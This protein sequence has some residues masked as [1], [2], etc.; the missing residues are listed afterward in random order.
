MKELCVNVNIII[1][2]QSNIELMKSAKSLLVAIAMIVITST[3]H[4][5]NF[6]TSI[7]GKVT[8]NNRQPIEAVTVLI[9][10]TTNGTF[11]DAQGNYTLKTP[12]GNLT[13]IIKSMLFETKEIKVK[14]AEG[15]IQ[16]VD[17][18]LED[19]NNIL[20]EIAVVGLTP[21]QQLRETPYNVTAVEAKK[22]HNLSADLN[23]VLNRT[24]GVR[25]RESGGMGSDFT[26]SLNGFSGNQVKFFLDGI[27]IDNYGP[28]FS[29]NNLP[30]NLAERIEVYKGVVPVHLGGDALGGAVNIITNKRLSK[31]LDAS[32]SIGSFNTHKLSINARYAEKNGLVINLNTFGNYSDNSYKVDVEI[33]DKTG[34]GKYLESRKYKRFHDGYKSGTIMLDLGVQGKSYADYLLFGMSIT[35]SKDE[36]QQGATM[37]K[38]IGEAY[39]DNNSFIPSLKYKKTNIFFE[40][41]TF[42]LSAAYN[43]AHRNLVDTCSKIYDWDGKYTLRKYDNGAND[44]AELGKKRLSKYD[45][46][47]LTTTSNLSYTINA[48]HSINLNYSFSNFR[49]DEDNEYKE[50]TK[51]QLPGKPKINK[52]ILG[53]SYNLKAFNE[54]LTFSAFTKMYSLYTKMVKDNN[55]I[56]SSRD[57]WG[58]GFASA[59]HISPELQAKASHEL[60]YRLPSDLEMLGDG[61][62]LISNVNIKPERSNNLNL[63]LA[64]VKNLNNTH[65]LNLEGGFIYRK[66]KNFIRNVVTGFN[67]Q[68]VN[69]KAIKVIGLDGVVRYAYSNWLQFETNA[70]WQRTTDASKLAKRE[71]DTY[72]YYYGE[73]IPNTPIFYMNS[74]LS[75]LLNNIFKKQDN[76]TLTL[77]ANYTA[78]YYLDWSMMG[79]KSRKKSI[80]EQFTQNVSIAYSL[81]HNKYNVSFECQNI[82]NKKVYDYYLVQRPG[83]SFNLKFRYFFSN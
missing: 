13:L 21:V 4:A 34:S 40:G 38:V 71:L 37:Q 46:K 70:T 26:F 5:Q 80:P 23:Q 31:Y 6:T 25:I 75:F 76:L 33:T 1:K 82:G 9:K 69:E 14:V 51:D 43:I 60:A 50:L 65:Y 44:L 54:K 52:N 56:S 15:Q 79:D 83:R 12:T 59:Y 3:L 16:V 53:L 66:A 58:Y 17:I 27:P 30:V 18:T 63:G 57:E 35:G 36:I 28:S 10:G 47:N 48:T 73:Q 78:S 7:K 61:A 22:L 62:V 42:D 64:Y 11:T 39:K 68:Y 77:G 72:N 24:T 74:D 81:G 41:L 29:L 49:R 67:N 55:M 32:Y 45:E 8:D 20:K 19:N 2:K